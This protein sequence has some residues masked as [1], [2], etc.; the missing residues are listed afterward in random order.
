[1][2]S[3]KAPPPPRPPNNH[4]KIKQSPIN[5]QFLWVK[6]NGFSI[7]EIQFKSVLLLW[8]NSQRGI[9]L[10]THNVTMVKIQ[11]LK[12]NYKYCMLRLNQFKFNLFVLNLA[13]KN[14][15]DGRGMSFCNG[16]ILPLKNM[17]V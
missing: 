8:V 3:K 16:N 17:L 9:L 15:F 14:I 12:K 7:I 13:I 5:C 1:M 11:F 10:C 4:K 2:F 6:I